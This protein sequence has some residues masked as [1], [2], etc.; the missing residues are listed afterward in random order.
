M[1]YAFDD[2]TL[3]TD[4]YELRR[5][6]TAVKLEPQAFAV[7]AYLVQHRERV[8]TKQELFDHLWAERFVGDKALERCIQIIRRALG[9][10]RSVPRFVQT[11]R[12]RGYRFISAV[13]PAS[14]PSAAPTPLCPPPATDSSPSPLPACLPC[15]SAAVLEGEH[16]LVTVMVCGL[17]QAATSAPPRDPEAGLHTMQRVF[18]LAQRAIQ[19]YE[20]TITHYGDGGVT[21]LFGAPL[22]HEDHARR[23]VLAALALQRA[24]QAGAEPALTPEA[25]LDVGI[26]LHTGPVLVGRLG[27]DSQHLYT[28]RGETTQ[29]AEHLQRCAEP[30]I[31]LASTATM[32]YV[33]DE[34]RVKDGG[35]VAYPG[36][37]AA[38]PTY[39]VIAYQPR[40]TLWRGPL[41]RPLSRFVGRRHE[42]GL[43]HD[44]LRHVHN[45]QGQVVG[46]VGEPGVGKS[47]LLY[48]F[49]HGLSE[50]QVTYLEGRC[51]SHSHNVPY[52]P[53]LDLLRQNCG[54]T[55]GDRAEVITAQIQ[56]SLHAVGFDPTIWAPYLSHLLGVQA[57]TADL[58]ELSPEVIKTRTLEVLWQMSLAGSRQRP[59]I[60][61]VEDLHWSDVTSE[62]CFTALVERLAGAPILCLFTYRSGYRPPWMDKSSM[63]QIALHRLASEESV[64][65]VQD[66]RQHL[67]PLPDEVL[68]TIVA[69]A[70]GNPFFLEELWR[71]VVEQRDGQ[72]VPDTIQAVLAA[73]LDRLAPDD[74]RLLQVAAVLG[75]EVPVPL[76]QAIT[77]QPEEE[78]QRRLQHLQATEFLYELRAFPERVY[79]FKHALTQDVAYHSLLQSTRQQYHRQIAQQL[80][81]RFRHTAAIQP[82]ILAHHYTEAGRGAQA[83]PYWHQ[84][85]QRAVERSAN[86]EAIAHL[87]R[88]LEALKHLPET[89]A[90]A[91]HELALHVAL[92]PPLL[93]QGQSADA[94]EH[95]HARTLTLCQAV[96]ESPQLFATLARLWRFY[97]DRAQL[98]KAHALGAQCFALAQRLRQPAL[99]QEAYLMQGSTALFLGHFTAARAALEQGVALYRR[100]PASSMAVSRGPDPGVMC[101]ARLAWTLWML[102][103][104]ER[105]EAA[106]ADALALAQQ[107]SHAYSLVFALQYA[108][109]LHRL[110]RD[111]SGVHQQAEA[112]ISL[113]SAQEFD[114]YVDVGRLWQGWV[115]AAQGA[116][117]A[118]IAQLS[119]GLQAWRAVVTEASLPHV[120]TLLAEAY[121]HGGYL[122]QGLSTL[123]EALGLVQKHA[124][125]HY[126]AELHWLKG[127]LLL[128]S[129]YTTAAE[130]C[131]QRSI[132]IARQQQAQSLELR[133][134]S[135]LARLW[136]GQGKTTEARQMLTA[137][138]ARFTEGFETP[139]LRE[140]RA[141][142]AVW[143]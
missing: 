2:W 77:D 122:P 72:A 58:G 79:T 35:L 8:V 88:G 5:T 6:G 91:Q 104:P 112:L 128:Q 99:L 137:L 66:L 55:A 64:Q 109:T 121:G 63:T 89:A 134:G 90:R 34:V 138:Y 38:L 94:V 17:S 115:R 139:D 69:K 11:L 98:Q 140:A 83:I 129:A 46:I 73:R 60:L 61:A 9:D 18:A 116:A 135:S 62:E 132:A 123:E 106:M 114:H 103:Y 50:Q 37:P 28:V 29:R 125:H 133:G 113:A 78:V 13:R 143:N 68:Q 86:R 27:P 3:N 141:L 20:G 40:R 127:E 110:R 30:G 67:V 126:E 131:L 57:A 49:C 117:E 41:E 39:R 10:H 107:V 130:T 119:Q 76:L 25:V 82:E 108:A 44:R 45:G 24:S 15:P 111:V 59:L 1:I 32:Q 136:H 75:R 19:H 95:S 14:P 31:I 43:L 97:L 4:L 84:A 22:A 53:V 80:A 52:M 85:G 12:S 96:D 54:V 65:M 7:L 36:T 124:Q 42:L 105:A 100:Q 71:S 56:K 16:K 142:L 102:G 87:H 26:G 120:L 33:Q 93:L 51:F 21:A 118:G 74:K 92:L 47:R 101:L 81:T 23:A 70:E 48:E